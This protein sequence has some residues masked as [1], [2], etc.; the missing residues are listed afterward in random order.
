MKKTLLKK[1]KFNIPSRY[2]NT[3]PESLREAKEEE[4][5]QLRNSILWILYLNDLREEKRRAILEKM[6]KYRAHIEKE[7]KTHPALNPA[8]VFLILPKKERQ[9]LVSHIRDV[10]KK[11][12]HHKT[13]TTRLLLNLIG[14]IWDKHLT[15]SENEYRFLLE[16]S[17]NPAGSFREWSRNTGLSL[18]G[19]KKIYEKLRKKISLRIISM[20]NFNALKLKHY[21]IHVRNIHRREFSEELKN[22]FMKL[23][24]NRS[25]MR[26]ASDPK[27]LTISMLIPSH[28]KCIRNFIKNIHLLEKTK[29]IKIDVY[30]VKEIFKSY[31]FSI[32]DPKVGWRFSPNEW[33]NL[34]ERNVE[35][36][37]RFNSIS[38][39]RMI[40]TTIPDF[41]LSKEDLRLISMLNMDFRIGNTVLKEVLKQSP[42][43]ISRRK[44]EFLEKGILIPVF[45]TAINLPNDVLIICEGSSETLDKVFYSSLYLPFVIGYRAKDIFSNTN[46]LFLYIRLH[47]ATI[48]DF[49]QICKELKKKIGLKEIYYEYQGTYCRSL[50]RFIERWD[51]EKQHWIW[52]TED[53]KLM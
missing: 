43:F 35:E 15:F 21:F 8:V 28:G 48:W 18:S 44:K 37:N 33:K 36:L 1:W 13:I 34:V 24:W 5:I 52:Y 32:F 46:L 47:S 42:S 40:Y 2:F 45:D 23:F 19:I 22:S 31:N 7:L 41:K 17:K 30:E 6:L 16:L 3:L 4:L 9:T 26:F 10:L 53:F 38:I 50:D 11:I 14:Y 20:V 25:V 39:H 27:V 29:K 49:I 12:E 51:E